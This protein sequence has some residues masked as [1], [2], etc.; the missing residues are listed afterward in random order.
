MRIRRAV[1]ATALVVLAG[2]I[3]NVRAEVVLETVTVGP[4]GN[5]PDTRYEAPGYGGVDYVY[6]IGKYEVT[7]A[8][9]A[10]FLNAVGATDT[11]GVYSIYMDGPSGGIARDGSAGS[12]TYSTIAGRGNMPV[13]RVSW[14]DAARFANWLH[15]GQPG[16][17]APVPQDA[18]STEDGSYYLDGATSDAGLMAVVRKEDATWVIPSEDEWYKAAY[19]VG[20][21]STLYYDYPTGG[22]SAPTAEGPPGTDMSD[23]SVNSDGVVGGLT[24]VGA[25]T[26]KP[27]DSAYGTFDQAGNVWEWNETEVANGPGWLRGLRGG[28]H[29][30]DDDALRAAHRDSLHPTLSATNIGFRVADVSEQGRDIPTVP[31]WGLATMALLVLTAGTLMWARRGA[32]GA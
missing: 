31:E 17:G 29:V 14:G 19:H 15:N 25:Y 5:A 8:Q 13:N 32:A 21:K 24:D 10:E 27:S 22:L 2:Q 6:N 18:N 9:Y 11:Y 16:L 7:N 26:A 4:A 20:G 23:G 28:S 30:D 12:Y 1:A 3:A